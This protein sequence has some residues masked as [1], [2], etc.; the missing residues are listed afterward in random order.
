MRKVDAASTTTEN[1]DPL[2]AIAEASTMTGQAWAART[3]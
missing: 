1:G 2:E 3:A